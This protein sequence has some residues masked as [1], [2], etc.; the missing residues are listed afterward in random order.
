MALRKKETSAT[1]TSL[2]EGSMA[3]EVRGALKA[4]ELKVA[5]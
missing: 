1:P 5:R 4:R 3:A 2:E